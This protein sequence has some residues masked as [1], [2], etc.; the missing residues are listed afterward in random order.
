MAIRIFGAKP[1]LIPTLISVLAVILG[2]ILGVWQLQRLH[3]KEGIIEARQQA[4]KAEPLAKLPERFEAD[5]HAFRRVKIS[6]RFRHDKEMYV[7]ARSLRGNPGYH[8]VTPFELAGGG[9]ILVN[10]GWGPLKAKEPSTRPKG[11]V[12]GTVAVEGLLRGPREKGY[13]VPENRPRE[14]FW[15]W[16]DVDAMAAHSGMNAKDGYYVELVA[17]Q[18]P[19]LYPLGGQARIDLPNNHLN[20]AITWFSVALTALVIY[21]LWHR[22]RGREQARRDGGADAA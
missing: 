18:T 13:F 17:N 7:A 10:R 1:A 2:V 20:Y 9:V 21:L 4:A 8:I 14:N 12:D 3:W 22:R 6:G 5:R 19:G 15:F 16:L 11:Q